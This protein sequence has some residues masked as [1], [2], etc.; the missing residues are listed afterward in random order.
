MA[1][2]DAKYRFVM[3]DVGAYGA[4]HDSTVF[5]GSDFGRAWLLKNPNLKVT[6]DKPLPGQAEY[7]PHF[8]V[9]VEAF[10]LKTNIM[11]PFPRSNLSQKRRLFN[12]S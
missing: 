4:N 11:T 5:S 1:V 9:D 2:V 3:V 8:L 6:N 10:G 7:I 12:Y